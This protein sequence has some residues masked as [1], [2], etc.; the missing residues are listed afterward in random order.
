MECG[1]R[2]GRGEL[3][4]DGCAGRVALPIPRRHFGGDSGQRR[5]PTTE[6][7]AGRHGHVELNHVQPTGLFG[8]VMP[9]ETLRQAPGTRHRA[10]SAGN[11]S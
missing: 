1:A 2:R 4:M 7:L 5:Q 11:V 9:S 6:T 10:S 8:G 3:P